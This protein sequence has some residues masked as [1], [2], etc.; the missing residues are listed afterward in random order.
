MYL[1][2]KQLVRHLTKTMLY[3]VQL[4]D[5]KAG[6]STVFTEINVTVPVVQV[7]ALW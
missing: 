3:F 7:S 1:D 5:V 6:G 2:I 4:N